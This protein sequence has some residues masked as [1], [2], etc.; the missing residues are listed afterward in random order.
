MSMRTRLIATIVGLGVMSSAVSANAAVLVKNGQP[1]DANVTFSQYQEDGWSRIP[2]YHVSNADDSIWCTPQQRANYNDPGDR[3][4]DSANCEEAMYASALKW[5]GYNV[6]PEDMRKAGAGYDNFLK[7]DTVYG[8]KIIW[9]Q[10]GSA[11]EE[12]EQVE[13]KKA[14]DYGNVVTASVG[15]QWHRVLVI[16][17]AVKDGVTWYEVLD[18]NTKGHVWWPEKC[19]LGDGRVVYKLSPMQAICK[20]NNVT[21]TTVKYTSKSGAEKEATIYYNSLEYYFPADIFADIYNDYD[22]SYLA[23]AKSSLI[24][25]NNQNNIA[26][27]QNGWVNI[28]NQLYSAAN[29]FNVVNGHIVVQDM[30][31]RIQGK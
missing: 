22:M 27:K 23:N 4:A 21:P 20:D 12:V 10:L 14:L 31:N 30:T 2:D 28:N 11:Y 7:N 16:G 5:C 15:D 19:T 26:I 1:Q 8:N 6:T 29:H 13:M 18:S 9:K 24:K 17:Y 3:T 25:N